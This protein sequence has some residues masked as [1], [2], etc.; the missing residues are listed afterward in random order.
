MLQGWY[1]CCY[2]YDYLDYLTTS[3]TGRVQGL[4]IR[5]SLSLPSIHEAEITNE[6]LFWGHGGIEPSENP[7]AAAGGEGVGPGALSEP[8][9]GGQM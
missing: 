1:R 9:A 6:I 2:D 4:G 3:A 7:T 5:A 8:I